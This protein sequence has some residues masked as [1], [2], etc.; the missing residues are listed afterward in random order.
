[1]KE[2]KGVF[3]GGGDAW[4]GLIVFG[5]RVLFVLRNDVIGGGSWCFRRTVVFGTCYFAG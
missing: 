2:V 3:V 5:W 1:M 4:W